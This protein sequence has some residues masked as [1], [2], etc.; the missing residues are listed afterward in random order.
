MSYLEGE[1]AGTLKRYCLVGGFGFL[2]S[3]I[4]NILIIYP[5]LALGALITYPISCL[6]RAITWIKIGGVSGVKLFR[7]TGALVGLLGMIV[8]LIALM[9]LK[10]MI[11]TWLIIIF[12]W[13]VYSIFELA[14]YNAAGATFGFKTFRFAMISIVGIILI[15]LFLA[16]I[17]LTSKAYGQ[18]PPYQLGIL[19]LLISSI[20][21]TVSFFKLRK[22]IE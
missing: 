4:T 17:S 20:M 3:F 9:G 21:A 12:P 14:S 19:F 2:F 6:L 15:L 16:P 1:V 5:I 22:R 10:G 8:Y 18:F 7:I 13:A 11:A